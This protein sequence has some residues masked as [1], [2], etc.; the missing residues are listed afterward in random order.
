[1]RAGT[2]RPN[3][4]AMCEPSPRDALPALTGAVWPVLV[5]SGIGV[6]FVA[7]PVTTGVVFVVFAA[8]VAGLV[9]AVRRV[10]GVLNRRFAPGI[11]PPAGGGPVR[12]TAWV[13]PVPAA[14]VSGRV[15]ALEGDRVWRSDELPGAAG[16]TSAY[17]Q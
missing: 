13:D 7:D 5:A 17:L 3:G 6:A 12:V 14:G 15:R 4:E 9:V 2:P 11:A 10:A 1:M 16:D 8:V